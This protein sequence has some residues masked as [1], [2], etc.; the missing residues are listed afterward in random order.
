VSPLRELHGLHARLIEQNRTLEHVHG[1]S[2]QARSQIDVPPPILGL[3]L[4]DCCG[5]LAGQT[6]CV[7]KIIVLKDAHGPSP[8]QRRQ[9]GLHRAAQR[10]VEGEQPRRFSR[11]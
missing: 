10:I 4:D 8:L 9:R 11:A 5:S 7:Q 3:A 6:G 1:W 2:I